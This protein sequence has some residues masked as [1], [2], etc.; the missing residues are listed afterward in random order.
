MPLQLGR[1]Y[2]LPVA[3][4]EP[5]PSH[6]TIEDLRA[7]QLLV[8]LSGLQDALN[9]M[10]APVV[11][12]AEPDLTAIVQAVTQLN[13]PA[14]AQEIALAVREV[15]DP[16]PQPT[17][18]PILLKLTEALDRLDFRL[19]GLSGGGGGGMVASRIENVVGTNLDTREAQIETRYDWQIGGTASVPLYI[20]TALP[21]TTTTTATWRI[22]KYTYITGPGGDA[23][24]SIVRTATGAW[25]SRAT[26]FI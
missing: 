19:K 3:P 9:S 16:S 15:I 1:E 4:V 13:G 6:V 20:G 21:G 8:A 26:L 11:H 17:V 18:E 2:L 23:V 25:D 22:D 10:P 14:S 12:V 24:P 5:E 7:E